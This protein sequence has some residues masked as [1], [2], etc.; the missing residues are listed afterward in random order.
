MPVARMMPGATPVAPMPITRARLLTS[1]SLAP[2][3]AARNEPESRARPRAARPRTT[4]PWMRSSAAIAGGGVGIRL[5]GRTGLGPLRERQHED[6]AETSGEPSECP[7]A[8]G[9]AT[10]RPHIVA[11][12]VDP[13]LFVARLGVGEREED[14]PFL[15]LAATREVTVDG[16]LG[17]LVGEVAT[18]AADLG[19]GG[20][21][22]V[23]RGGLRL[24]SRHNRRPTRRSSSRRLRASAARHR[25]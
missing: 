10:P 2:N 3:T 6:G 13:V 18:P 11:E 12:E 25:C 19:P 7:R 5:V 20:R 4:S 24:V 21:R 16:T 9:T 15:A 8:E 22:G 1:P 14:R 23:V 17:A